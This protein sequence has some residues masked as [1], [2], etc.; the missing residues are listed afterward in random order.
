[1]A[2]I[3]P[4]PLVMARGLLTLNDAFPNALTGS[5]IFNN[6]TDLTFNPDVETAGYLDFDYFGNRSGDKVAS[7]L[8]HQLA[9]DDGTLDNTSILK[10]AGILKVRYQRKWE[11]LW[12][13]YAIQ[14]WFDNI[15]IVEVGTQNDTTEE[16][17]TTE[18]EFSE[19]NSRTSTGTDAKTG[20]DTNTSIKSGSIQSSDSGTTS[21]RSSE[22]GN[23][24]TATSHTG[25]ISDSGSSSG[26][27]FSFG[28]NTTGNDGNLTEK[29]TGSDSNTRTLANT[30]T[31]TETPNLI[32]DDV[33]TH[34]KV[35]TDSFNNLQD[36]TSTL[37]GSTVTQNRS[38]SGT[39][40]NTNSV[41]SNKNGSL[42]RSN[43]NS[44]TGYDF[45]RQDK[46]KNLIE[47]FENPNLFPFFEIVFEDVDDILCIPVF[48]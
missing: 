15:A 27:G 36:Q 13:A 30:D 28:F 43:R 14:P 47:L 26:S 39:R 25:T 22:T 19:T 6:M 41:T 16:E 45:R 2:T 42:S 12:N 7:K 37:F 23:K 24:Q 10:L 32:T 20:T 18:G 34:G 44:V 21:I 35:S 8:I 33:T 5:G 46:I 48:K 17:K 40:A 3:I 29:E 9:A 31:T 4:T 1:M 38:I 11:Q